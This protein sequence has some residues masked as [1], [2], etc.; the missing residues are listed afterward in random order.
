MTE[1]EAL[2]GRIEI[3]PQR[4]A[5]G[6]PEAVLHEIRSHAREAVP[7]ECCGLVFGASGSGAEGAGR[8]DRVYRC[9]NVMDRM[10]QEDPLA[11]PRTNRT[12]F[13]IDPAELLAAAR[14]AEAAGQEVTAV[15]HSHVGAAAYFSEMDEAFATQPGFPFP[16]AD[17]LVVSVLGRHVQEMALFRLGADGVLEGHPVESISS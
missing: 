13:F 15:Y 12:A 10:N 4:P 7:D 17:H 9:R 2:A 14:E 6:V 1:P 5:V 8:F 16:K 3:D 11:Y